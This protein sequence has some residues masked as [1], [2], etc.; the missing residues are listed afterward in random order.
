MKKYYI[1]E[2][3]YWSKSKGTFTSE[4]GATRKKLDYWSDF[5]DEGAKKNRIKYLKLTGMLMILV[6]RLLGSD[7]KP[8]LVYA[9]QEDRQ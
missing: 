6:M 3:G 7:L 2:G 5:E 4:D 9:R 1:Y 8:K